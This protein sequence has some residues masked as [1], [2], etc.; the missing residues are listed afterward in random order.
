MQEENFKTACRMRSLW[1]KQE[2]VFAKT[3][4]KNPHW[5]ALRKQWKP[6][7]TFDESVIS[8]RY[9]GV[10]ELFQKRPYTVFRMNAHKYWTMGA[11]L[12]DTL[13]INRKRLQPSS[14]FDSIAAMYDSLFQDE[15]SLIENTE[16]AQRLPARG[17]ILDIG[18]GTGGFLDYTS[19]PPEQYFGIDTSL[20]MLERLH[21]KHP[22][23]DAQT[24]N[25]A[26]EDF[27]PEQF[28]RYDTVLALFGSLN[29]V[30][31]KAWNR[32]PFFLRKGGQ[33]FLMLYRNGYYPE[34]NLRS[35][36]DI[37]F[38][39]TPSNLPWKNIEV[40]E[41]HNFLI[42]RYENQKGIR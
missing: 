28:L 25:V 36:A 33:F 30:N 12:S 2:W 11:P 38:F 14:A 6:A 39:I 5:Y 41:Y 24:L 31:P 35:G 37:P 13:L 15:T 3:M 19:V 26:F 10:V 20:L 40:K 17:S 7:D 8:I 9:H 1:S 42:V 21:T 16:I 18:C 4:P 32:L 23:F 29:Y 34:T 22:A 27:Y